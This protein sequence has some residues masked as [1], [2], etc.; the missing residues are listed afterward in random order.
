M[1][2]DL[3]KRHIEEADAAVAFAQQVRKFHRRRTNTSDEQR[4][5][6]I[7]RALKRLKDAMQPLRSVRGKFQY[8]PQTSIV[9]AHVETVRVASDAI[10]RERRKLWKMQRN[11][12]A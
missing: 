4:Q 5:A 7:E 12:D 8:A 10:Q 1:S 11:L 6:D 9:L 3:P 2:I